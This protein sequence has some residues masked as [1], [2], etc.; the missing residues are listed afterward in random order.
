M[1]YAGGLEPPN[2]TNVLRV[3]VPFTANSSHVVG[4]NN[5]RVPAQSTSDN[6]GSRFAFQNEFPDNCPPTEAAP[7]KGIFF[8]CHRNR[9]PTDAD[10]TTA[11]QRGCYVGQCECRRRSY[12]ILKNR[13]DALGLVEKSP[14]VFRY[15]SR[16]KLQAENGVCKATPSKNSRSHHSF[17]RY[18]DQSMRQIFDEQA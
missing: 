14:Q 2:T 17:W 10:F 18:E 5:M 7:A 16:G 9:P 12:S 11:A 3:Q 1:E 6:S 8:I 4:A 15:V 13:E